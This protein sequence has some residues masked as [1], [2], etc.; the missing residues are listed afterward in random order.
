MRTERAERSDS[1]YIEL[2]LIVGPD[3][4]PYIRIRLPRDN[5]GQGTMFVLKSLDDAIPGTLAGLVDAIEP[6]T[7]IQQGLENVPHQ[8]IRSETVGTGFDRSFHGCI[9]KLSC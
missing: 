3:I 7:Y 4:Y 9:G 6:M 8:R 2:I 5:G 1:A